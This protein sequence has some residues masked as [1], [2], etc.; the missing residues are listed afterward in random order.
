LEDTYTNRNYQATVISVGGASLSPGAELARYQSDAE[1]NFYNFRSAAFDAL[2]AEAVATTDDAE[3]VKLY[4]EAQQIISDEAA[5]VFIQD[6]AGLSALN[7][8]YEGLVGYPLY[9]VTDFS[10]VKKV[11]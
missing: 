6:I 10:L 1:D 5:N 2:Y 9:A 11:S 3:K 4:K 8:S 7:K